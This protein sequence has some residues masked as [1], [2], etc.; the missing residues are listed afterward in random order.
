MMLIVSLAVLL[1]LQTYINDRMELFKDEVIRQ[2]EGVLGGSIEYDSISP[3]VFRFFE[4]RKLRISAETPEGPRFIEINRVRILYN[5]LPFF[6]GRISDAL[7][8]I[9]IENSRFTIDM[10]RDSQFVDFLLSR[11]R[12]SGGGTAESTLIISGKNL[13]LSLSG[14]YGKVTLEK[15]FFDLDIGTATMDIRSK[16]NAQIILNDENSPVRRIDS[17][18]TMNGAVSRGL[19][20]SN[21]NCTVTEVDTEILELN[22]LTA[23]IQLD[24]NELK[25]RK[26]QD[27]S[28]FDVEFTYTFSEKELRASYISLDFIPSMVFRPKTADPLLRALF[29]T[30]ISGSSNGFVEFNGMN[31]GYEGDL[32]LHFPTSVTGRYLPPQL[33]NAQ[34]DSRIAFKGTRK[35]IT[36]Y[37]FSIVSAAGVVTYDGTLDIERGFPDGRLRI[38]NA[39]Y[40]DYNRPVDADITLDATDTR[41]NILGGIRF[42]NQLI[43]DIQSE[44]TL[45]GEDTSFLVA[46][47]I[48]SPEERFSIGGSL[49]NNGDINISGNI[50]DMHAKSLAALSGRM[51]LDVLDD[52][53]VDA[54]FLYTSKDDQ[55]SFQVKPVRM[56]VITNPENSLELEIDGSG[57]GYSLILHSFQYNGTRASGFAR[58]E[59][60]AGNNG[61][62]VSNFSIDAHTYDI[63]GLFW[64][65]DKIAFTGNY[66]LE[67]LFYLKDKGDFSV[68]VENAPVPAGKGQTASF[69]L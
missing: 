54:D 26:I 62:F 60:I 8:E 11:I 13:E 4:I 3:S 56:S 5:L 45:A 36:L 59:K 18:F 35:E 23:N 16:G 42:G 9:R 67:G 51:A 19:D 25:F 28:P 50:R 34:I 69:S 48:D 6:T 46:G 61:T 7:K 49:T 2:I 31:V 58:Y 15:V 14:N 64:D 20:W 39:R 27:K 43:G 40:P 53:H 65:G 21:V 12:S 33:R 66:G 57:T 10:E 55:V 52:L 47:F 22:K 44:V 32:A 63:Q 17:G 41:L 30:S 29:D 38:R 68:R 37:P 1:P 24:R